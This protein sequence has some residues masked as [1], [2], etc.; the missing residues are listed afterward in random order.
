MKPIER[1]AVFLHFKSISPHSFERNIHL[2]NGYYAKQLKNLGSVGSDIL[3]KIHDYFPD[4]NILWVLTGEGQMILEDASKV[5]NAILDDFSLRYESEN[6]KIKSMESDLEKLN[7]LIKDKEKI[8]GLYEFML[9]TH[10]HAT[11]IA[12]I[13][14]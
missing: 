5:N 10:N 7:T 3:I 11:T 8:I 13:R 4:L 2:S 14:Q 1:I 9:N 12:D 6:K